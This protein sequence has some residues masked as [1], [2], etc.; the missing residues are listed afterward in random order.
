MSSQ[1]AHSSSCDPCSSGRF[2]ELIPSRC[3]PRVAAN[4][5]YLQTCQYKTCKRH[6]YDIDMDYVLNVTVG[7]ATCSEVIRFESRGYLSKNSS[8]FLEDLRKGRLD[9]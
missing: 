4:Q 9:T 3:W 8:P 1:A 2:G 5:K 6:Q 7:G